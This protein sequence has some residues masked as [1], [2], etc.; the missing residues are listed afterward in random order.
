MTR[1]KIFAM[2]MYLAL[3]KYY[4]DSISASVKKAL[5]EK[6]EAKSNK[7]NKGKGE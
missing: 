4:S 6:N 2:H 5:K 1:D 3:S 7:N